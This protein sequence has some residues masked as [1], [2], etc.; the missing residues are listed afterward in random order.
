[1]IYVPNPSEVNNT[2]WKQGK[3]KSASDGI[4]P[5]TFKY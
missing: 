5:E 2:E 3:C 4:N 1:M